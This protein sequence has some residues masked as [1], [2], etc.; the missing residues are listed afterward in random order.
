MESSFVRA[1]YHPK[2]SVED[3]TTPPPPTFIYMAERVWKLQGIEGLT[4]GLMPTILAAIL[5]TFFWP[6]GMFKLYISPSPCTMRTLP[7]SL[8]S[9][10]LYTILVVTIYRFV[11]TILLYFRA[12]D[13]SPRA[14]VTPRKL[15]PLNTREALHILFSVHER[16]KPWAI[17]Q[18]PGLFPAILA[19]L[20]FN[21]FVLRPLRELAVPYAPFSG[22]EYAVPEIIRVVVVLFATIVLAPLEVIV[23]RLALQRNYGGLAFI[24]DLDVESPPAAAAQSAPLVAFFPILV[25]VE[26][27][28]EADMTEPLSEKTTYPVK[29]SADGQTVTVQPE[30]LVAPPPTGTNSP[31]TDLE[32][33]PVMV[34]SD[35]VVVHE[36]APYLGLLDCG[37]R[38]IAEEGWPVLYRMWFLTFLGN[39][40]L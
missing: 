36:N 39:M 35:G 15:D 38:I 16:K 17:Y 1:S 33:G 9:A 30:I 21:I 27:N 10:L 8:I 6:G 28:P 19:I 34:E 14:I 26:S 2:S 37:K 11:T 22:L 5:L 29:K 3:G 20:A 40:F 13:S 24:G 12:L 23:T 25:A 18:I 31:G 7:S 32:R 4:K